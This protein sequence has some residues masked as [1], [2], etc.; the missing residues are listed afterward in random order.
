VLSGWLQGKI[1][2]CHILIKEVFCSFLHTQFLFHKKTCVISHT[3]VDLSSA[4]PPPMLRWRSIVFVLYVSVYQRVPKVNASTYKVMYWHGR[5]HG[6]RA[7]L[8]VYS[9]QQREGF[10]GGGT[11]QSYSVGGGSWI[12]TH[13]TIRHSIFTWNMYICRHAQQ[14]KHTLY[15]HAMLLEDDFNMGGC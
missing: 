13:T 1:A 11:Q 12:D 14:H 5:F 6:D 3:C 2:P 10:G 8:S 7:E 15:A 4:S 9:V